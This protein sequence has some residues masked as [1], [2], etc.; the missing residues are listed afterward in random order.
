[1]LRRYAVAWGYLAC[2]ALTG[3]VYARL[4]PPARAA[5]A[6]WAS[7]NVANLSHE[8]AGPLVVS[9]IVIALICGTWLARALAAADFAILVFPGQIFGGLSHLDVSAVGHLTALLTAAAAIAAMR[10]R[11]AAGEP[12]DKPAAA[13]EPQETI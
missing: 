2:L 10:A 5:V 8:A 13:G 1:M 3:L 12:Q 11:G 9:A 4:S 6:A 7:T